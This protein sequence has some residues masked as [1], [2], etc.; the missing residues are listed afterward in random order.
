MIQQPSAGADVS[1]SICE[2]ASIID[3]SNYLSGADIG[4]FWIDPI[5][6]NTT[7]TFDPSTS[8][9]GT[10]LYLVPGV[11]G[12][13]NDTSEINMTLF[14]P[15]S[16]IIIPAGPFCSNDSIFQLFS[17]VAGGIWSGSAINSVTGV[18]DPSSALIGQNEIIYSISGLCGDADT[19]I[20]IVNDIPAVDAGADQNI[21]PG[22][23]IPL[24]G[25]GGA[26]YLWTPPSGLSCTNCPDP[27]ASPIITTLYTLTTIDF[28]GCTNTDEV[29]IIVD[30]T[31]RDLFI[32]NV[33]SPNGDNNN[34]FFVVEGTGLSDFNLRVFNRWG[35]L[36]FNSEDQSISWDGTYRSKQLNSAV[37]A[38]MFSYT[39]SYGANQIISGN[40]TLI[41]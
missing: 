9:P 37:F 29:L 3:L 33:F 32:P 31:P 36:V 23:T 25:T 41:K 24:N 18:F 26:S 6:N 1:D 38:Y 8:L 27:D 15:I 17:N 4:G 5:G 2:L 14:N 11:G 13:E 22:E 16:A 12:C 7:N 21:Q 10:Y 30:E 39:D 20:I 40:V 28:N 19:I 34:D 35:E